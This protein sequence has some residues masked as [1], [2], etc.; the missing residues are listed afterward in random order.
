MRILVRLECLIES[1]PCLVGSMPSDQIT[2]YCGGGAAR[3]DDEPSLVA[4]HRQHD[5]TLS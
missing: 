1:M 2:S 5:H 4:E 3:Q